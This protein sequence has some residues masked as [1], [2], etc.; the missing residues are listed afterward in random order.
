VTNLRGGKPDRSTS[1]Q[2]G[3]AGFHQGAM[4]NLFKAGRRRPPRFVLVGILVVLLIAGGIFWENIGAYWVHVLIRHGGDAWL[5]VAADSP[6]LSPSMRLALSGSTSAVAVDFQWKEIRP[7]FEVGELPAAVGGQE[8]DRVF[9]ARIDPARYRF[10]VFNDPSGESGLAEWMKNLGAALVV[11]GSYYSHRARPDTP[12]LS[13]GILLGP[14]D[15]DA[16]A[17]A[18]VSSPS[19][20]TIRDLSNEDWRTAFQ[21]AD[22]AMV[23]FPLLIRNGVPYNGVASQWLA[24]RSF[25]GQDSAGRIIIGTTKDGFFSLHRFARFLHDAPLGLTYAL[26]LD[27]GPVACQGI[28]LN[29][30]ERNT[31]GQWELQYSGDHGK[32]LT[33]PFGTWEMPIVLAVFP[34]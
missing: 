14:A 2:I 18:F 8:V 5:P 6:R 26:N 32:L 20:T 15:Y 1:G 21:G 22:N 13:N 19:V 33:C 27:G 4:R 31:I 16:K 34:K 30:F 17:G 7:G 23:S 25:V 10:A 28:A 12:F 3:Q 29:G 24:N 9:L 11:N